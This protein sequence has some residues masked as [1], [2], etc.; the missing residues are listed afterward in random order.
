MR[1]ATQIKIGDCRRPPHRI[2][3]ARSAALEELLWVELKAH[4]NESWHRCLTAA[5]HAESI[6]LATPIPSTRLLSRP[7]Q[8]QIRVLLRNPRVPV[9][10]QSLT[11]TH[12]LELAPDTIARDFMAAAS[13]YGA[14]DLVEPVIAEYAF[15]W[16][17]D[18][19]I[20]SEDVSSA[21][22][23]AWPEGRLFVTHLH[24]DGRTF[25][26]RT[27]SKPW[28]PAW[29]DRVL[30]PWFGLQRGRPILAGMEWLP[31]C[32]LEKEAS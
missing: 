10:W 20:A 4:H 25:H 26:L 24:D 29:R 8:H 1:L 23:G 9:I 17:E 7:Q 30:V 18:Y 21:L 6:D 15:A 3:E 13:A 28:G 22:K 5:A 31:F 32:G 16:A 27:R 19:A 11:P 14:S 2:E 12:G